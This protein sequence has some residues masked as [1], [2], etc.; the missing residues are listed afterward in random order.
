MHIN[1]MRQESETDPSPTSDLRM[2]VPQLLI[3]DVLLHQ[4]N[5]DGEFPESEDGCLVVLLRN[6]SRHRAQVPRIPR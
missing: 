2:N 6:K 5:L 3:Y 1:H 4:M